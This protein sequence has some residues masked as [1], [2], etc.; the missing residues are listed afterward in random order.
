[1]TISVSKIPSCGTFLVRSTFF[2]RAALLEADDI[3]KVITPELFASSLCG[4]YG[5]PA[6]SFS[7]KIAAVIHERIAE[8]RDQIAPAE[9]PGPSLR[10]KLDE[11]GDDD[12]KALVEVFR[13]IREVDDDETE[14]DS[15]PVSDE[16]RTD[17]GVD[18]DDQVKVVTFEDTDMDMDEKRQQERPMTVEELS[19]SLEGESGE[20]L[21]LLIK[22]DIMVGVQNLSDTFEW[23][24]NSEV[25]PEEFA[26]SYCRELGLSGE[27]MYVPILVSQQ[28]DSSLS[29]STALSHDIHEQIM[30]QRRCLF[31]TGHIFG[32]GLELDDEVKTSF[33]PPIRNVLRTEQVAMSSFTPIFATFTD[34]DIAAIEKERDRDSK[35][36]RRATRA[37]RGVILPDREPAK[38]HRTLLKLVGPNGIMAQTTETTAPAPVQSSR[39]AAAIAAQANINLLAQ[40]LPI[41]QPPTPPANPVHSRVGKARGRAPGVGR[42]NYPRGSPSTFDQNGDNN[43]PLPASAL[44]RSFREESASEV[45]SPS[46]KASRHR[47]GM[48]PATSEDQQVKFEQGHGHGTFT[49]V[50][51]GLNESKRKSEDMHG[52]SHDARDPKAPRMDLNPGQNQPLQPHPSDGSSTMSTQSMPQKWA[53]K[54]QNQ[55]RSVPSSSASDSGSES[56]DSDYGAPKKPA[57]AAGVQK[58]VTP[59]P[60]VVSTGGGGGGG[61]AISPVS[62]MKQEVCWRFSDTRPGRSG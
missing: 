33:L 45:N 6:A 43:S 54:S 51:S 38:T 55:N 46:A 50:P 36:K 8:Y 27:F 39:R 40:D 12:S 62:Y 9:Q 4:D 26:A 10:G 7:A 16:I 56:S 49:H 59:A 3:D 35:R 21:R 29:C 42:G 60:R 44:K 22:I 5:I 53:E 25:T 18:N 47:N 14:T 37:R 41:P 34:E 61:K 32:S 11:P 30:V 19:A 1:M 48:S 15:S 2:S 31:L 24:I 28:S 20:D 52:H 23:D 17:S 13:R 58:S 57:A